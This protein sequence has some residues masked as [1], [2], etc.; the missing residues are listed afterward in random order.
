MMKTRWFVALVPFLFLVLSGCGTPGVAGQIRVYVA[1]M[2]LTED[3]RVREVGPVVDA[4]VLVLTPEKVLGHTRTL[5]DGWSAEIQV[6]APLDGRYQFLQNWLEKAK[7][8][9]ES[10]DIPGAVDLLVLKEGYR[11][12]LVTGVPVLKGQTTAYPVELWRDEEIV[13]H[14]FH[15]P[16]GKPHTMAIAPRADVPATEKLIEAIKSEAERNLPFPLP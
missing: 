2:A 10:P 6:R 1:E 15:F 5:G 4:L 14:E 13:T 16:A 8:S 7:H 12:T 11:P 9:K 3:E